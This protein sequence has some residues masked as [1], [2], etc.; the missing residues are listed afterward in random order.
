MVLVMQNVALHADECLD[1]SQ[2]FVDVVIG[3]G[4]SITAADQKRLAGADELTVGQH[5]LARSSI[6][7]GQWCYAVVISEGHRQVYGCD[8]T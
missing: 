7:G 2:E 8:N 5:V 6:Y 4:D 3:Y 1:K